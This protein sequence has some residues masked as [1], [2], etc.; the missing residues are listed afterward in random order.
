MFCIHAHIHTTK[1]KT[2]VHVHTAKR[3]TQTT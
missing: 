1:R 2:H 3:E